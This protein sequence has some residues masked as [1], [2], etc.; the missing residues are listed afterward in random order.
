[1]L[2]KNVFV[3][4]AKAPRKSGTR[5]DWVSRII[6]LSADARVYAGVG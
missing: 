3:K 1:M 4:N 5:D 2:V 6:S